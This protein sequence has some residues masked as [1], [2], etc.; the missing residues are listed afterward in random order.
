MRSLNKNKQKLMYSVQQSA[1]SS[2]VVDDEGNVV[3]DEIDGNMVART[4]DDAE[5]LT[6]SVPKTFYGNIHS[7][8]GQ[9]EAQS[10]GVSIGDYDAVLYMP[11]GTVDLSETSLIWYDSEPKYSDDAKTKVIPSSADYLVQRVPP[12]LDERVYLLKRVDK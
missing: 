11:K 1:E 8:G 5:T 2:N 3:Y 4:T 12:C 9:A 6:Y 7:S 10:Y